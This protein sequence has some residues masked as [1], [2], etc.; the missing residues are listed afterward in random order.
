MESRLLRWIACS[1]LALLHD[2]FIEA[3]ALA[4]EFHLRLLVADHRGQGALV[5]GGS[6]AGEHLHHFDGFMVHRDVP[7]VTSSQQFLDDLSTHLRI[8][9]GFTISFN[10]KEHFSFTETHRLVP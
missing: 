4:R 7:P 8:T 6:G 9:T 10:V 1:D 5:R 3:E 2:R